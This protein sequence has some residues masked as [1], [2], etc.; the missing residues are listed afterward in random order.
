MTPLPPSGSAPPP[1]TPP[2]TGGVTATPLGREA[3]PSKPLSSSHAS[4]GSGDRCCDA[5]AAD[6]SYPMDR[7]LGPARDYL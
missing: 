4:E 1:S 2:T 6:A 3:D 5:I 7:N